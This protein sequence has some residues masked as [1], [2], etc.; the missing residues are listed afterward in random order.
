MERGSRYI[1]FFLLEKYPS[2]KRHAIPG[3]QQPQ[4]AK[5]SQKDCQSTKAHRVFVL[6]SID[7]PLSAEIMLKVAQYEA[8]NPS[9]CGRSVVRLAAHHSL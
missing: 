6:Q 1:P 3:W 5:E 2:T 9:F 7:K 8:F 4:N